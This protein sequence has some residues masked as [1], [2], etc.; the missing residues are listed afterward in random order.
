MMASYTNPETHQGRLRL[1]VQGST[2][3]QS[4]GLD[5]VLSVHSTGSGLAFCY[6]LFTYLYHG[7]ARANA[8]AGRANR[9]EQVP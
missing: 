4:I 2:W 6:S 3:S 5:Q 1:R 8:F 7:F 9:T